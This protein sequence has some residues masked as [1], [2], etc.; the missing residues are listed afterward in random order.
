[1][2][3]GLEHIQ[4]HPLELPVIPPHLR[5]S[6][7]Y[8]FKLL[9]LFLLSH[10]GEVEK[11]NGRARLRTCPCMVRDSPAQAALQQSSRAHLEGHGYCWGL[12]YRG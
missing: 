2:T 4:A 12:I 7:E 3:T 11:D 1:M 6:G 10:R 9:S 8:N 5:S